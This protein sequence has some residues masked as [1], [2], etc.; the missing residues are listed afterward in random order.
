MARGIGNPLWAKGGKSP[1]PNGRPLGFSIVAH[2]KAKLQEVPEGQKETY[3]NLITKKYLHKALVEGDPAILKDLINRVD[4]KAVQRLANPDGT[5]LF[6]IPLAD[7]REN[8]SD[9]ENPQIKE[10]N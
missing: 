10:K 9:K 3:A 2:L 6:P 1:N 8:H 4:G 5:N 7:V